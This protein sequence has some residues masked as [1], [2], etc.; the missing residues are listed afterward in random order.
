[1]EQIPVIMRQLR[2]EEACISLKDLAINGDDLI[3]IGVA[4]GKRIGEILSGL[5]EEVV[6]ERLP[7]DREALLRAAEALLG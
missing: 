4:R 6:E 2:E 5:L 1:M 7:N 3:A